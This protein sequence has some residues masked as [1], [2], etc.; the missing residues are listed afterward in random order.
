MKNSAT[1]TRMHTG[2]NTIKKRSTAT[3]GIPSRRNPHVAHAAAGIKRVIS[4]GQTGVDRAALDVALELGIACGGRC[5]KYRRAEDGMIDLRYP[6]IETEDE[7]YTERTVRNVVDADGTLILNR[8]ILS[9]GTALTRRIAQQKKR[10]CL[11]IDVTEPPA[12]ETVWAWIADQ[13]IEVLNV[14]GP[15][16]SRHQKIYDNA[17]R[18]LMELLNSRANP[19]PISHQKID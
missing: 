14:A 18:F 7:G 3:H 10:P 2:R 1:G 19:R 17:R 13:G 9:G 6:L 4:G 15:R 12:P 11:V 8:G 16:E 5:P